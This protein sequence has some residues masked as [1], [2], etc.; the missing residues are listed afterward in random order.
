MALEHIVLGEFVLL[1]RA[2]RGLPIGLRE[3][4]VAVRKVI[5]EVMLTRRNSA[6]KATENIA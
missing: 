1:I 5:K 6:D 2:A 3:F 4:K